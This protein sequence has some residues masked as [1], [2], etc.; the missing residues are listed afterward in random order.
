MSAPKDDQESKWNCKICLDELK[1]PVVTQCGHL[2]CWNCLYRWLDQHSTCPVCQGGIDKSLITPIFGHGND[3]D[4]KE[5]SDESVPERPRGNR[6]EPP[7]R[8]NAGTHFEVHF[9][10]FGIF[11]LM[12]QAFNAITTQGG[13]GANDTTMTEQEKFDDICSK[14]IIF[15]LLVVICGIISGII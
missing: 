5:K 1:K 2:F 4:G 8:R 6:Q 10:G 13:A 14:G 15:C 11:D 12:M 9:F 3:D 7:P